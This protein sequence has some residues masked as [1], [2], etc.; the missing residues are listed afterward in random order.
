VNSDLLRLGGAFAVGLVG[1]L[2]LRDLRITGGAEWIA[3][4][5]LGAVA[6]GIARGLRG[7]AALMAGLASSY[8]RAFALSLIAFL[9]ENWPVYAILG[10]A[11]AALG[12]AGARLFMARRSAAP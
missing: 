7:F 5:F 8:P 11:V 12:S 3:V 9:G 1:W 10:I 4:L 6:G 2:V